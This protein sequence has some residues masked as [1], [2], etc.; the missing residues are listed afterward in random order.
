MNINCD[1]LK[2][3]RDEDE[4]D[5]QDVRKRFLTEKARPVLMKTFL[6]GRKPTG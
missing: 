3:F 2:A 4:K 5:V 6:P 1:L